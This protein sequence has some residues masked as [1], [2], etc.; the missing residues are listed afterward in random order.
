MPESIAAEDGI[1]AKHTLVES[2]P[3]R[4]RLRQ[5]SRWTLPIAKEGSLPKSSTEDS[6]KNSGEQENEANIR[7]QREKK[8]KED[9]KK[10]KKLLVF[11]TSKEA[12]G[13]TETPDYYWKDN[14]ETTSSAIFGSV[15]HALPFDHSQK[16]LPKTP[17]EVDQTIRTFSTALPHLSSVLKDTELQQS[18]PKESLIL[19]FQPNPFFKEYKSTRAYGAAALSAF[20]PIEMRFHVD[21]T[22]KA[23]EL[24]SVH[25]VLKEVGTDLML[26]DHAVDVRFYQ[27]TTSQLQ[28]RWL[29]SKTIKDFLSASNL[30]YEGRRL[31]LPPT[32]SLPIASHLCSD[33]ALKVLR[34][35]PEADFHNV[36][37][38][39]VGREAKRTLLF[40]FEDWKLAYTHIDSGRTGGR[41]NE[42]QLR[43]IRSKEDGTQE[44]FVDSV[45][46]LAESFGTGIMASST[47]R[48]IT[49]RDDLT[50]MFVVN[51]DTQ[52]PVERVF[53]HTA[54]RTEWMD[55]LL[56][57]GEWWSRVED[58]KNADVDNE[59]L[60]GD[61]GREDGV[62][63]EQD[64]QVEDLNTRGSKD[65]A[66]AEQPTEDFERASVSE[67]V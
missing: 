33:P 56:S 23:L 18:A 25:A 38:L 12:S 52:K 36:E 35:D 17:F 4:D 43:P 5:W 32:I 31:D 8:K 47:V 57:K 48:R 49:V 15:L 65:E 30:T 54:K 10:K 11:K 6:I 44:M 1:Y 26:P 42:L 60:V 63:S 45:Y 34:K 20:P 9:P 55:D 41:K 2:L 19:H 22:T 39:F 16:P 61:K 59:G 13:S 51:K 40:E 7:Y 14:H 21:T 66:S 67:K 28:S 24:I 64:G 58:G 46:N 27:K 29:N 3:W 53:T 50:R 37:Y 62:A